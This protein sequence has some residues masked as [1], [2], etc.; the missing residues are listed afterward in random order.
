MARQSSVRRRRGATDSSAADSTTT[1]TTTEVDSSPATASSSQSTQKLRTP[2]ELITREYEALKNFGLLTT[3]VLMFFMY[4]IANTPLPPPGRVFSVVFDAGSTG[5]R[6]QVFE[7]RKDQSSKSLRLIDTKMFKSEKSLAALATG[8][9]APGPFFKPLLTKVKKAV[10]GVRRK[11]RTPI[12]LRATAGLRLL[13]KERAERAL[14]L[15]RKALNSSGFLFKEEY[16]GVMEEEDEAAL[17]W[18]TVNYLRGAFDHDSDEELVGALE[19]G[20][21]SMQIVYQKEQGTSNDES[22]DT[23]EDEESEDAPHPAEMDSIVRVMNKDYTLHTKS[24]LGFGL[25]DFLKKLY[26]IFESEGVLEEG[27]PCFRKD[28]VFKN[29]KL[30]FGVPGSE[31]TRVVTFT[32]DGD[33]NR[34]VA[35]AEI[36]IGTFSDLFSKKN[37]LPK[38]KE[39]YAFAYFYDRTVG[40]GISSPVSKKHLWKKGKSLCETP[41]DEFI[42]EARDEACV[43]FAYVYALLKLFTKDFSSDGANV[44]IEQFIEGHMLGWALGMALETV[45]PVMHMQL[46]LDNEALIK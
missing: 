30:K 16:V 43:E 37:R 4:M 20:G 18:T 33:F 10:P 31:E 12:V 3:A 32:G 24:Y 11:Q 1:S 9:S 22:E 13:G 41:E 46:S 7:F 42:G 28:K 23:D 2:E 14:G 15:A 27:N 34:C 40:S 35:S 38:G 25:F 44:R 5:T 19:L 45:E 6:A 8:M 21:A 36:T 29:K 26:S 17:A 39:F